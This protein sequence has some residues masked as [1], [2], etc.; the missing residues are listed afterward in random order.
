LITVHLSI[1][2]CL[3]TTIIGCDSADEHC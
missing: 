3:F 2:I 1:I